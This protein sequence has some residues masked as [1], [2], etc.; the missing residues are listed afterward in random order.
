MNPKPSILSYTEA[1]RLLMIRSAVPTAA[2]IEQAYAARI[3][4]W[5][6][7]HRFTDKLEDRLRAEDALKLLPLARNV[8]LTHVSSKRSRQASPAQRA[9]PARAAKPASR[10]PCSAGRT[11][12]QNARAAWS[13]F[14]AVW[15]IICCVIRGLFVSFRQMPEILNQFQAVGVPKIAVILAIVI[16]WLSLVHGCASILHGQN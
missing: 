14:E 13:L 8:A 12:Y 5:R 4:D 11:S 1:L 10:T 15:R 3:K 2:E 9:T 16:G 7:R 6:L